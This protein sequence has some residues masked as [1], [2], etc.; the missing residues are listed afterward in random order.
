MSVNIRISEDQLSSDLALMPE[1]T[2]SAELTDITTKLSK[3][4]Q[5]PVSWFIWTVTSDPLEPIDEELFP[6]LQGSTVGKK[7]LDSYSLQENAIWRLNQIFKILTQ[8][9][10]PTDQDYSME[11][12]NEM[13]KER[14]V[15]SDVTM[16]LSIEEDNNGVQRNRPESIVPQQRRKARRGKRKK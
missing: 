7:V 3:S 5:Q 1:D 9:N 11:E 2:Y 6:D 15:G 10:L 14:L 13:L 8:E 16:Q 12:F 4:S